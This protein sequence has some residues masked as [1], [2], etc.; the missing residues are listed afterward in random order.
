[1]ATSSNSVHSRFSNHLS[2]ISMK[3]C[4]FGGRLSVLVYRQ[5]QHVDGAQGLVIYRN[6]CEVVVQASNCV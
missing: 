1:M 3:A 4:E 6:L 5:P 2:K